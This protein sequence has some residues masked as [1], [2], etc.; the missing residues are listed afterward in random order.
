VRDRDPGRALTRVAELP[1]HMRA[2]AREALGIARAPHQRRATVRSTPRPGANA[3]TAPIALLV[4]MPPQS[5]NTGGRGKSRHW[6]VGNREKR[7]YHATL[8]VIAQ[9]RHL[10]SAGGTTFEI[11]PAPAVPFHRV[12]LSAHLRLGGAMDDDNAIGRMKA[13][14]DW[15]VKRGYIA[16]DRRERKKDGAGCTWSAL[17]TQRVSRSAEPCVSLTISPLEL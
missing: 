7:Q 6:S 14:V 8:D 2:A 9:L 17:P 16:T 12:R 4:P 1:A 11:P 15:L 3:S 10:E 13:L 5:T